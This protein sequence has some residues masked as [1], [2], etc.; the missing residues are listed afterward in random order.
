MEDLR[1]G[2]RDWVHRLYSRFIMNCALGSLQVVLKEAVWW[3]GWN[4]VACK[5]NTLPAVNSLVGEEGVNLKTKVFNSNEH[6]L[7]NKMMH[8][9]IFWGT[10]KNRTHFL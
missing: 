2:Y 9:S 4:L 10:K 8:L 3:L 1:S 6:V 5:A 7:C